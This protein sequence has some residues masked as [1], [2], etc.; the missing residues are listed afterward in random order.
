MV[1][2]LPYYIIVHDTCSSGVYSYNYVHLLY[3]SPSTFL[4]ECLSLSLSLSLTHTHTHTHSFT[5]SLS[6][7]L[8]TDNKAGMTVIYVLHKV[9]KYMLPQW[10]IMIIFYPIKRKSLFNDAN[11]EDTETLSWVDKPV[12]HLTTRC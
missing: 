10:A 5:H 9:I 8:Q 12:S 2:Q 11:V 7:T 1:V 3:L 4:S 6:F